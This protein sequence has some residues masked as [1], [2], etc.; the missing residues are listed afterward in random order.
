MKRIQE[1]YNKQLQLREIFGWLPN[2]SLLVQSQQWNY[3]NNMSNIFKVNNNDTFFLVNFW[4][5]SHIVL[6]FLLLNLNK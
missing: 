5:V 3:Q 4:F 6:V 1:K 2:Q